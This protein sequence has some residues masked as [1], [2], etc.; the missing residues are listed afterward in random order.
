MVE[1]LFLK[2]GDLYDY[3][4]KEKSDLKDEIESLDSN[5]LLNVS[6]DDLYHYLI[7]KHKH[8]APLLKVSELYV[9]DQK[10]VDADISEFQSSYPMF[11]GRP[12]RIKCTSITIAI[13]FDGESTLFHYQ[14]STFLTP[15]RQGQIMREEIHLM[16]RIKDYDAEKFKEQYS[17]DISNI[18][19][20]LNWLQQD[21]EKYNQ[22]LEELTRSIITQ[23]KKRLLDTQRMV[24]TLGIPVKRRDDAPKTYSVPEIR[25]KTAIELPR[26][27][28]E[29]FKPEPTLPK[30]EY[31]NILNII[32]NMVLV[33]ERS[34]NAFK[35]MNEEDLR[36]HFLVQLNGQYEGLA[37]GET[38]NYGGKTDILIRIENRN[39]FIAE[40]K[41]WKGEKELLR[42][43]DQLLRY[44]SWRDTKTAILLFNKQKE[45]SKV[46]EKIPEAVKSHHCFKRDLGMK[47]ETVFRYIFHQLDDI[48]REFILTVMAFNIS[49]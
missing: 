21:I 46:L 15:S 18:Q 1:N 4:E 41:F 32:Q 27:T 13:P 49:T 44:V 3:L 5:Y 43:V 30:E 26:V 29:P 23:R 24:A 16:Y 35:N 7:S 8:N 6:E 40:C 39:V 48:N 11:D 33:M 36:E 38:F 45:F 34:P 9:Y 2:K 10:E 20:M 19:K 31:E 22:S 14:P 25:R 28:T 42:A 37:T 12:L 47:E 17:K